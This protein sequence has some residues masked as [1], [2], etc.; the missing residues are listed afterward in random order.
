MIKKL[1]FA[2][3]AVGIS[4]SS[5]FYD[6]EEDLYPSGE[7][8]TLNVSFANDVQPILIVNCLSCHNAI[9]SEGTVNLDGHAFV[10]KYAN[11]GQLVGSITHSSGYQNMP[12]SAPKLEPCKIAKIESWVQAGSPNN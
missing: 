3:I 9:L 10:L 4:F 1:Y 8:N 5:C 2:L 11:S 7:C 12:Q 6:S